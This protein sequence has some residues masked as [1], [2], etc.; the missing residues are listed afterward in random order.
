MSSISR[1]PTA[2]DLANE[3]QDVATVT[4]PQEPVQEAAPAARSRSNRISMM[5]ARFEVEDGAAPADSGAPAGGKLAVSTSAGSPSMDA[6]DAAAA[7]APTRRPVS[8]V[9][10]TP[11]ATPGAD[12]NICQV[13]EKMTY[14]LDRLTTNGATFHKTCFRCAECNSVLRMGN[15]SALAGAFYCTP[16][17]KQLF[18][19]KG[20]YDEGFGRTQHKHKWT[21]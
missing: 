20:N 13:C 12:S 5:M 17:F 6:A 21:A 10:N 15:F 3:A 4:T 16:H 7:P 1:S 18:R 19:L 11:P 14:P 9:F 8:T 2:E